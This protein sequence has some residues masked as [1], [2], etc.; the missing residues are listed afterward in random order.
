MRPERRGAFL[1][2]FAKAQGKQD[3]QAGLWHEARSKTPP[4]AKERSGWGT[5]RV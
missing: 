1:R 2:P 4:F 3:K 5:R